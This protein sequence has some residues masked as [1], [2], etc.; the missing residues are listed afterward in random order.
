MRGPSDFI[1]RTFAR[2]VPDS[3]ILD[4]SCG[5]GFQAEALAML[6][7]DVFA[8][9]ESTEN[10]AAARQ[11]L[12]ATWNA[13]ELPKR[14]VV[15]KNRALGYPD[16]YFDWVIAFGAFDDAS[17]AAELVEQ[18]LEMRRVLKP[19]GWVLAAIGKN[20]VGPDAT[21]K[22]LA[23]LFHDTGFAIANNPEE[24]EEEGSTL[25]RGIF[26]KVDEVVIP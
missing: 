12:S 9:D 13:E 8:C 14:I 6:G 15:A 21:P 7:F 25:L 26:R 22:A 20:V 3:R 16:N 19:G 17:D 2:E 11:R 4:L 1:L 18:V 23:V 24:V 10:V 5:L